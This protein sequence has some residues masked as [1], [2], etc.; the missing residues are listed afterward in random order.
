M[1]QS[2]SRYTWLVL[3][4]VL[5]SAVALA[6]CQPGATSNIE[7]AATDV[8]IVVLPGEPEKRFIS[9]ELVAQDNC[10]GT[11]ET[12]FAVTR[13]HTVAYEIEVGASLTANAEGKVSVQG[14]GLVGVGAEVATHYQVGYGRQERVSRTVTLSA[15]PDT[16]IQHTIEHFEVW[17]KG[18][19]LI[20][21]GNQEQQLPYS[22]RRDFGIEVGRPVNVDCAAD[23]EFLTSQGDAA[24]SPRDH[25]AVT[26][27]NALPLVY[28]QLVYEED[29]ER[30][31]E[32][33]SLQGHSHIQNGQLTIAPGTGAAP[34]SEE[35]Y[36]DFIFELT[37]QPVTDAPNGELSLF[38]HFQAHQCPIPNC[39]IVISVNHAQ[40]VLTVR[41]IT[42]TGSTR[43]VSNVTVPALSTENWNKVTAVVRDSTYSIFVNGSHV[44]IFN[45]TTYQSGTFLLWSEGDGQE[46]TALSINSVRVYTLP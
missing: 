1:Y 38:L 37:V 4:W 43:L 22:F 3:L 45:D 14:V 32:T 34:I 41:K 33:W 28:G 36:T 5:F 25:S 26:R 17:E 40:Q 9:S 29:F 46:R 13:E 8:Q 11:A 19:V 42:T 35:E 30:D 7:I 12:S 21:A 18:D 39:G 15:A 23:E 2:I 44:T 16:Y 10:T 6:A 20:K 31:D 24:N 27:I